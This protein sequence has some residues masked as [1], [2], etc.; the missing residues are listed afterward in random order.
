MPT[1]S[2]VAAGH[3]PAPPEFS[4][5]LGAIDKAIAPGQRWGKQMQAKLDALLE[6]EEQLRRDAEFLRKEKE[7]WE[8]ARN[9][10]PTKP[11]QQPVKEQEA[12]DSPPKEQEAVLEIEAGD[13]P[14]TKEPVQEDAEEK[15]AGDSPPTKESRS[16]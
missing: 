11:V 2:A 3:V 8:E 12:G 10:P 1:R 15:E 5:E 6:R 9:S 14:P 7:E 16:N 4:K 13:S